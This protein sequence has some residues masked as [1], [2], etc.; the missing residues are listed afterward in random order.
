MK[1][2]MKILG[3]N[4]RD[5]VTGFEGVATSISFDL[6]G[7]VQVV[8]S[9]PGIDKDGKPFIGHWFDHKRLVILGYKP[10]MEVPSFEVVP[11][12]QELPSQ[13]RY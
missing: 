3:L 7:C 6:Y 12:G 10:V 9:P 8:V 4:V 13:G 2:Y 5:V 1:E 11:G